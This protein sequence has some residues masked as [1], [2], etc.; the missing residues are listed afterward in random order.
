MRKGRARTPYYWLAGWKC[1]R[2]DDAGT[3]RSQEEEEQ[4]RNV[5]GF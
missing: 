5:A 2:V 4:R 3:V 1:G